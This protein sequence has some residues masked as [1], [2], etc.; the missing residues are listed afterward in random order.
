[1]KR[2][3]Q[4]LRVGMSRTKQK[5]FQI[6]IQKNPGGIWTAKR[7]RDKTNTELTEETKME[8]QKRSLPQRSVMGKEKSTQMINIVYLDIH[9]RERE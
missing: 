5:S 8:I 6:A 2:I 3:I 9:R 4:Y 7:K 1:M